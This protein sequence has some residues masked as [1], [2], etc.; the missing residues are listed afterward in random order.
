M[1]KQGSNSKFGN[2][3]P[4][5]SPVLQGSSIRNN[6]FDPFSMKTTL[7]ATCAIT[8]DICFRL[9]GS[10]HAFVHQS[11]NKVQ[12]ITVQHSAVQCN[13]VLLYS[14]AQHSHRI[15]YK[16]FKTDNECLSLNITYN[17]K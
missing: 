15:V 6:L 16:M 14:T 7:Q 4:S 9:L 13:T 17:Y 1:L 3:S 2:I 5:S 10:L 11:Y 8:Q 12:Y